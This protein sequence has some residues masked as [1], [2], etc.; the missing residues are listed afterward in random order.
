[1]RSYLIVANRTLASPT[2]A[3]AVA[4]RV[5]AGEA[6]FHVVVPRTPVQHG[7]TW[8][9]D[10]AEAA[11]QQRLDDVLARLKSMGVAATGEVGS[12]DPVD[13]VHDALRGREADEIILSTLPVRASRWLGQDVPTKLRRS[14]NV[15]VEV[16][17]APD[18]GAPVAAGLRRPG[19]RRSRAP[20]RH[21]QE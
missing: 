10:E 18:D 15:P 17:I 13:A 2:L 1:M 3:A 4:Q 11:A 20:R 9:E 8:D 21:D 16:V 12:K 5:A 19:S 6:T 7:L 14:V